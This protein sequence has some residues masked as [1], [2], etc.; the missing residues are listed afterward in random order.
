MT[1]VQCMRKTS[2]VTKLSTT[3][4]STP[5]LLVQVVAHVPYK[6]GG[7]EAATQVATRLTKL[8]KN[9]CIYGPR[10]H[11]QDLEIRMDTSIPR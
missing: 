2:Q 3:L 11:Y 5:V 1:L 6:S 9:T 10:L 4:K 8:G 7:P